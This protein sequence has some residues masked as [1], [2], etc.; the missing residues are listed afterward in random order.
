M[1]R[2]PR[3]LLSVLLLGSVCLTP[4]LPAAAQ[5]A[6]QLW[7]DFCHYVRIANP[8][9]A[10]EAAGQ[11]VNIDSGQLLD[12]VESSRFGDPSNI[13]RRTDR[14]EDISEQADTIE[15]M[16]QQARIDRSRETERIAADIESLSKGQRAFTNAVERLSAAGQFAA[17]QL[18]AALADR[19]NADTH[20][21]IMQAMI[22]IGRPMVAPLSVALPQLNPVT[23]S[24]VARVLAEIGYPQAIPA[25]R[26]V[27]DNPATDATASE[28]AAAA[29]NVLS[30]NTRVSPGLTAAELY[31]E[32]GLGTYNTATKSPAALDGY[33]TTND[34][35][36]V[37]M[38][39]PKLT[40]GGDPGLTPIVVPGAI[41]GDVLA[42]KAAEKSLALDSDLDGALSL[43]LAA[44]LRRENRLPDGATDPSYGPSRQAPSYYAMVAGPKRL[45]DVLTMALDDRDVDLALDAIEGLSATASLDALQPLV[46]GL[47]YPDRRV[48]FRSAEALAYAHPTESFNQDF[49]VVP[50]MAD[51]VRQSDAKYAVVISPSQESRNALLSALG[52]LEYTTSD[53][54][55]V[56][57]AAGIVATTPGI[58]LIVVEGDAST[59]GL[60][61]EA[62]E[63]NYKLASSA[64]IA[65]TT[66]AG[67]P[68]LSAKYEDDP[69]VSV[70]AQAD[71]LAAAIEY[72]VANY[73]GEAI[74]EDQATEFALSALSLLEDIAASDDTVFDIQDAMPSLVLSVSD[75]REAVAV[76]SGDVLAKIDD[77]GAQGAIAIAAVNG[78]G[79]AQIELLKDLAVSANA[80][81]NLISAEM[82]DQILELVKTSTGDLANA[83]AQAHGALA[84][85][86]SNAV[87]LILAK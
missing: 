18:L 39:N 38:Y 10:S 64:I 21:Q 16:I 9:L 68:S 58:D 26:E 71:D 52:D 37:W 84:L 56:A 70:I 75:D 49:R 59:I 48:R 83:A 62:T 35:G 69:R 25:L 36:V 45:H 23:Q 27:M 24:Q 31:L 72:A 14:M 77:A 1:S 82:S 54:P 81:G 80:F 40:I 34:T 42:M 87:D 65:L 5:D 32:L 47:N 78:S 86:T 55:T 2:P 6:D 28:A 43:Y 50:V 73:S 57:A 41:L 76:A 63:A 85:P 17:P 53:G 3:V 22:D 7:A 46:R 12:A 44:N 8:A 19:A 66:P 13:F 15:R 4:P 79:N 61:I 67:L 51:A 11:L 29:V 33:D 74:S 30:E 60:T 20:S